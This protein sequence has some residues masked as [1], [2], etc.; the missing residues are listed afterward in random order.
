MLQQ[1]IGV[2]LIL[3]LVILVN[4]WSF[5]AAAQDTTTLPE[6][7]V[8]AKNYKYL[9]SVSHKEVAQPI[10]LVERKSASFDVMN[11]EFYEDDYDNYFITFYLPE[12]YVLAVYDEDGKLI[13][14]AE[15]Y[16]NV[17][18]PSAV[19]KAVADRYPKWAVTEDTYQVKYNDKTGA[20]MTYKLVLRNGKK[21]I[22]VK[23]NEKGEFLD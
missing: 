3:I 7:V 22:R 14:T 6:V 2:D 23:T 1:R 4:G 16:K 13:R 20:Q 19:R 11:S 10:R 5:D 15:R 21:Q 17:A 8:L 9:R 12:G 18:L